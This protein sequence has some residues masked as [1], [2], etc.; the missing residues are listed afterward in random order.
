MVARASDGTLADFALIRRLR[1]TFPLE[2]EGCYG[3]WLHEVV[4]LADFALI[5]RWRDTFP[6]R[7]K[8]FLGD[9]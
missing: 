5:R 1:A 7:G 8:A 3:G 9:S 6:A 2:G 4:P